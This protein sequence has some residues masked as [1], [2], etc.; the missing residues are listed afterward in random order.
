MSNPFPFPVKLNKDGSIKQVVRGTWDKIENHKIFTDWLFEKLE[1][2][3]VEDLYKLTKKIF[4]DNHGHGLLKN[5][6]KSSPYQYIHNINIFCC[7]GC[8]YKRLILYGKILNIINYMQ[9]G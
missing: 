5:K 1:Y 8:L 9:N 2:R 3:I 6:Y 4:V 7:L